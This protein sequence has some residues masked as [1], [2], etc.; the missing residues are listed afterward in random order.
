MYRL[1]GHIAVF[2]INLSSA[3]LGWTLLLLVPLHN[4]NLLEQPFVHQ[5]VFMVHRPANQV[6][7]LLALL[8]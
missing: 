8:A 2:F 3:L 5:H 6:Y 1:E 4:T 7:L